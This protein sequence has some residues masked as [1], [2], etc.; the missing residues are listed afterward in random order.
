MKI[1]RSINEYKGGPSAVALG[2]FDGL[3]LAHMEIIGQTVAFDSRLEPLIFTMSGNPKEAARLLTGDM[4]AD[5]LHNAGVNCIVCPA[6]SY[7]K[8]MSPE[9]FVKDVLK[10]T[11][12]AAVVFCGY[13]YRFGKNGAGDCH[14]L[15]Q[16]CTEYGIKCQIISPVTYDGEP[17]SSSRIRECLFEGNA[18]MAAHLLGRP[19]CYD[20]TVISGNKLGR[21]MHTPTINQRFPSDFCVPKHG[22]YASCTVINNKVYSSVTNIGLRPTVGD[23]KSPLSETWIAD[24]SGDLY[25]KNVRVYILQFLRPEQKFDG[26]DKLRK[27]ILKD[28]E[29]AKFI[30]EQ[31]IKDYKI[32]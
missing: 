17:V 21:L 2:F 6:F 4:Y 13:N 12:N 25:G 20:F 30:T 3:H 10:D 32:I 22:V 28:A 16:L 15:K 7:V 14:L 27:A 23:E 9:Q 19:F 26:I 18:H 29:A 1:I 31:I 8:D 11:L 24:F 5:I